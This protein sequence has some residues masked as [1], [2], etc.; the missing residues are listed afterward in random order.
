[1][2]AGLFILL[3]DWKKQSIRQCLPSIFFLSHGLYL[4]L[5]IPSCDSRVTGCTV[6]IMV[7]I[8]KPLIQLIGIDTGGGNGF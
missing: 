2:E 3:I 5:A 8:R 6:N 7:S 4:K 1:M